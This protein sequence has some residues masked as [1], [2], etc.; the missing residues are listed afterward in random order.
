MCR[1][2]DLSV[3]PGILEMIGDGARDRARND[4]AVENV[5]PGRSRDG[6]QFVADGSFD[7]FLRRLEDQYP[8]S[9][10]GEFTG[11]SDDLISLSGPGR[12]SREPDQPSVIGV[13]PW[14]CVLPLMLFLSDIFMRIV[15]HVASAVLIDAFASLAGRVF[16]LGHRATCFVA[17][18]RC[19][20]GAA[21][22][23]AASF[24]SPA[25]FSVLRGSGVH[26]ISETAGFARVVRREFSF[27]DRRYP[28]HGPRTE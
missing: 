1:E 11:S 28:H 14:W 20:R 27:S 3:R 21:S 4:I 18:D 23:L 16:L 10:S 26:C 9:G 7:Q 12:G 8:L 5:M 13:G 6:K 24:S 22:P 15:R 2:H 25:L 19:L 17:K